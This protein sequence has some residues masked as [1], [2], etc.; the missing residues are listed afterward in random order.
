MRPM[1]RQHTP[2]PDQDP[3]ESVESIESL[4]ARLEAADPAEA[5]AIADELAS[6]L[7]D[8]LDEGGTP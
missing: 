3:S 7:A 1:D 5:P 2:P 8:R 4:Q 6:R